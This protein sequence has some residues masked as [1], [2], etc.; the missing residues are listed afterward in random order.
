MG[1]VAALQTH[2]AGRLDWLEW[3]D[4]VKGVFDAVEQ[5]L[6][7]HADDSEIARLATVSDRLAV[8]DAS[9][10]TRPCYEAAFRLQQATGHAFNPR[11]RGPDTLDFGAIAKGFAVDCAAAALM[12]DFPGCECLI[13]LGGNLKAVG[14]NWKTGV[15]DPANSGFATIVELRDGEAL[16]TSATYFRG[17]H[18]YDGRTGKPVANG[19]ASVTVLAA[20]ALLADGLSTALFVFGPADGRAFLEA[21]ADDFKQNKILAV[22]WLMEDGTRKT[23]GDH[24]RFQGN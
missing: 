2:D 4:A 21:H 8:R 22:L 24:A 11:W 20:S 1:T 13:D 14:G 12:H 9:A 15:K 7:A 10:L 6:N 3:R 5:A 19:V 18:I 17:K 23:Y 16:A